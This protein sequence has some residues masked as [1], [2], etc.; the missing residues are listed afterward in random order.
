MSR[1]IK[2]KRKYRNPRQSALTLITSTQATLQIVRMLISCSSRK[3]ENARF[4]HCYATKSCTR[5]ALPLTTSAEAPSP[6]DMQDDTQANGN[7]KSQAI[8]GMSLCQAE[9]TKCSHTDRKWH[10]R[11]KNL[12]CVSSAATKKPQTTN[13]SPWPKQAPD[14][15]FCLKVTFQFVYL[16]LADILL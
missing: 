11:D 6:R 5:A 15:Q 3:H 14:F 9:E 2:K 4:K 10:L 1:D 16:C 13:P 8:V 7:H 12:F